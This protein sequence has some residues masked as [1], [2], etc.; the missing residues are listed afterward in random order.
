[1]CFVTSFISTDPR[2]TLVVT[3]ISALFSH[4]LLVPARDPS[5]YQI[6]RTGREREE[7]GRDASFK[8][9]LL[10]SA[11]AMFTAS[12]RPDLA[13]LHVSWG[14]NGSSFSDFFLVSLTPQ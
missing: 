7:Q 3:G 10:S 1:M 12:A 8:G 9:V 11:A 4:Q 13:S 14:D 5:V 2:Q 6:D